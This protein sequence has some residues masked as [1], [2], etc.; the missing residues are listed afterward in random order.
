MKVGLGRAGGL[1]CGI[2]SR[3][4]VSFNT[5]QIYPP[6]NCWTEMR[7]YGSYRDSQF[8]AP[9]MRTFVQPDGSTH[10]TLQVGQALWGDVEI[11]PHSVRAHFEFLVIVPNGWVGLEED[12][13]YVTIPEFVAPSAR[14]GVWEDE[15]FA[16]AAI[17]MEVDCLPIPQDADGRFARWVRL[18]A[19]PVGTKTYRGGALPLSRR[20]T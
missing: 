14:V 12:F 7:R 2:K 11:D 20:M 15:Q 5:E 17:E 10:A 19:L 1:P 3:F 4:G 18:A 9:H 6:F 13:R 8:S 16:V